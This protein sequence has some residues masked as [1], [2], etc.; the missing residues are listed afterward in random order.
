MSWYLWR[1]SPRRSDSSTASKTADSSAIAGVSPPPLVAALDRKASRYSLLETIAAC[2]VVAGIVVEDWDAFGMFYNRPDWA[3]GR[4]AV[5]GAVVAAGIVLELWFGSRSSKAERKIRDWY[6]LR[7]AELNAETARVNLE[8]ARLKAPRS[9]NNRE[10]LISALLPLSGTEFTFGSVFGDEES[11]RFLEQLDQV[12]AAAG[13]RRIKKTAATLGIT[14]VTITGKDDVVDLNTKTGVRV[15]VEATE[16]LEALRAL[17]I[18]KLPSH[19][20]LAIVLNGILLLHVSPQETL[21]AVPV[22]NVVSGSS[23]VIR[24]LVGKK[25]S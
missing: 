4:V 10:G 6:A 23:I 7:V 16:T 19:I 5:G 1:R 11:F 15:E 22:V 14:A 13:W 17:P 2:S 3:I 12:F 25:P 18:D 9:I 21:P 24:V 20:R 8:L